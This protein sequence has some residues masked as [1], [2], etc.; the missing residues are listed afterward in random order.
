MAPGRKDKGAVPKANR[1]FR[2]TESQPRTRGGKAFAVEKRQVQMELFAK[3]AEAKSTV[4]DTKTKAGGERDTGRR[5]VPKPQVP[6]FVNTTKG[7]LSAEME[8]VCGRLES[9]L[10]HVVSNQGV[11]GPNHQTVQELKANWVSIKPKLTEALLSG[12][13]FPGDI[14]RVWIPKS[15]GG[16]R[17]L[18]IPNVIDRVVQEAVRE[19]LEPRYDPKFHVSSHGFRPKRSCHTAIAEAKG[20]MKDGPGLNLEVQHLF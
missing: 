2:R 17:G 6:M 13:Y 3:P 20:Y 5:T 1:K 10:A 8:S 18:G 12:T 7:N 16:E 19:V 9:A 11:A 15:G 4:P 14:R